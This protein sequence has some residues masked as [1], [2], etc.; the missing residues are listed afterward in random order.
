MSAAYS[1]SFSF[2]FRVQRKHRKCYCNFVLLTII[3]PQKFNETGNWNFLPQSDHIFPQTDLD[4]YLHDLMHWAAACVIFGSN[5]FKNLQ[6]FIFILFLL[7]IFSCV[8]ICKCDAYEHIPLA[9]LYMYSL[10]VGTCIQ[11]I[12]IH[13]CV[14]TCVTTSCTSMCVCS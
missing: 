9:T 6:D 7:W 8:N 12:H 11:Y 2:Y 10:Y 3:N 1:V 13:T 4:V 5:V 14:C